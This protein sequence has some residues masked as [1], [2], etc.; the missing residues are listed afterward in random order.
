CSTRMREIDCP[1]VCAKIHSKPRHNGR[2]RVCDNDYYRLR[3]RRSGQTADRETPVT[4]RLGRI[5]LNAIYGA[6]YINDYEYASRSNSPH[7]CTDRG[8]NK[9]PVPVMMRFKLKHAGSY[10]KARNYGPA[11]TRAATVR[12]L[13]NMFNVMYAL[14]MYQFVTVEETRAE[15][16]YRLV[17]RQDII[18]L[19]NILIR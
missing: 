13:L 17:Y 18:T 6:T 9:G 16:V 7:V 19:M 11:I 8:P 14:A 2:G 12:R 3:A 1:V 4:T 10:E 15:S 5:T